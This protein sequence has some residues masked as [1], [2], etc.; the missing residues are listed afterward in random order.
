VGS[1]FADDE[2]ELEAA[3]RLAPNAAIVIHY[4]GW[5]SSFGKAERGAA[6]IERAIRLDPSY[7]VWA[8]RAFGAAYFMAGRYGEAIVMLERLGTERFVRW[9]WAV[10]GAAL[11]AVGRQG[12]AAEIVRQGLAQHP[13][14]SIELVM[15]DPSWTEQEIETLVAWMRPAGFP[16]C[17]PPEALAEVAEPRRLPECTGA[18]GRLPGRGRA[19]RR[20][21]WP[22][23]IPSRA[24]P[25]TTA[26]SA[27]RS[28]RRR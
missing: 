7:P 12:Q 21:R 25:T 18:T 15:N 1:A 13:E 5:A 27:R 3:L 11:A 28:S 22:T 9:T 10:H 20:W 4:I 6:L 23:P 8:N 26:T 2:A 19:G 24:R 14:L 17:A 16:A